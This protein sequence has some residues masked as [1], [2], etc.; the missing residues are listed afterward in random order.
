MCIKGWQLQERKRRRPHGTYRCSPTISGCVRQSCVLVTRH[1]DSPKQRVIKE[2]QSPVRSKGHRAR[3]RTRQKTLSVMQVHDPFR[4]QGWRQKRR[5][6]YLPH[7]TPG[8]KAKAWGQSL[9]PWGNS[10]QVGILD[11][12]SQSIGTSELMSDF[13]NLWVQGKAVHIWRNRQM[14]CQR[15]GVKGGLYSHILLSPQEYTQNHRS[16]NA[17]FPMG[18]YTKLQVFES[19]FSTNYVNILLSVCGEKKPHLFS[20][21]TCTEVLSCNCSFNPYWPLYTSAISTHL[22]LKTSEAAFCLQQSPSQVF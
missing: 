4:K 21:S 2:A 6:A 9:D 1:T 3:D 5:Q 14:M 16:L 15:C 17:F 8:L 18:I 19:S 12:A 7:H 20:N 10:A 22:Y 13:C 11:E